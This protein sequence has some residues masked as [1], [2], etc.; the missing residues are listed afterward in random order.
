MKRML[1]I[2][3]LL[4]SLLVA[5]NGNKQVPELVEGPSKELSAID[6]LMWQ[7]PDSAL[8]LLKDYLVCRDVSRNVSEYDKGTQ[9]DVLGNVSTTEY[10]R[11]YANLL[12]AELLYKNDY[13]QTNR[14]ELQQAVVYLDSLILIPSSHVLAI[15][16]HCGLDPQSPQQNGIIPF[17]DARAHYINGVGYYEHD[18][19]VEAC[20]EYLKVLEVMED[21]YEEKDISGKK[22]KFMALTYTHLTGLFSN[23]Y[24]H[25][26]ALY[27]GKESLKYYQKY[28]AE[29]WHVAWM[30]NKIGSRYILLDNYDSAYYYYN[31]GLQILPDTNSLTFRDIETYQAYLSYKN[32]GDA[33]AYLNQMSI[34]I[35]RANSDKEICSRCLSV[36]EFFYQ[37][38]Q[39]DSAWH[40]FNKVFQYTQSEDSK[41]LAAERLIEICKVQGKE[42]ES[43]EYV[44]FLLPFANQ[45]E[46]KSAVKSQLTEQ[47]KNYGQRRQERWHQQ[48]KMKS[49]RQ[50]MII[51]VCLL[52]LISSVSILYIKNKK[53]KQKL[54]TQIETERHAHQMQQAALSG[55]LKRSNAELKEL[56]KR[57]TS[58]P[59]VASPQHLHG[60]DDYLDEPICK[61][62]LAVCNDKSNPIKSTITIS[63]YA[64]IALSDLQKAQLKDAAM[65]HYG[66]LF[67]TLKQQHPELKEK[68]LF[69]CYLCLLGLD[70]VQIAVLQQNSISTIWDRENRLKKIFGSDDKVSV[71]LFGFINNQ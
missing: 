57:Q 37:E 15:W 38:K 44:D 64:N 19:V 27:F 3:L 21:W 5:C 34:L 51:V 35:S 14:R 60:V 53:K 65:R 68:D 29:A 36:G 6:S 9:G 71:I 7:Q 40:Y 17:L 47:Y 66:Q 43:S 8:A 4:L 70:N 54:E 39:Y 61:H 55:R 48:E 59:P 12:L 26:Q 46:I 42:P 30:L 22:A 11:H 18:S 1:S 23:L 41:K 63:A 52:A 32:G 16:R 25:E 62:I 20:K 56:E 58:A 28:D 13:E 49:Q 24:L 50:T 45:E 67:E 2:G 31:Q 10:D 33:T 69:F